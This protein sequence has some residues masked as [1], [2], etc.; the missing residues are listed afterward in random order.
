MKTY[1]EEFGFVVAEEV[2]EE[3]WILMGF[4]TILEYERHGLNIC[5]TRPR[6]R[7]GNRE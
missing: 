5:E 4:D 1:A 2:D 3:T 6:E 7:R